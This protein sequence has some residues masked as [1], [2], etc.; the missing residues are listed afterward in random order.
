MP[1]MHVKSLPPWKIGLT[2]AVGVL[3]YV[4]F[5]A[6]SIQTINGW[7]GDNFFPNPFLGI[8]FFLTAFVFS[9][10]VCGGAILGYPL[11]LLFEKNVRRAVI[12]IC[13]SAGWLALALSTALV[14]VIGYSL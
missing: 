3:C 2:Q 12:I 11:V 1:P 7:L 13:W 4:L 9:A 8:A 6:L 14:V 10:L 5:F